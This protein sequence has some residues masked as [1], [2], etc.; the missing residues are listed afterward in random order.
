MYKPDFFAKI[1]VKKSWVQL[2]HQT[3]AFRVSKLAC[4]GHKLTENLQR[5][6]LS[7]EVVGLK[8]PFVC[9][10]WF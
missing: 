2:I 5:L 7:V 8:E 3:I 1:L 9:I 10:F 6:L 4:K